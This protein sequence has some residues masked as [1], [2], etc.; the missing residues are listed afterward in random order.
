M[1]QKPSL[2]LFL[3]VDWKCWTWKWRI[4]KFAGYEIAGHEIDGP[5]CR[6]WNSRTWQWRTNLQDIKWNCKTWNYRTWNCRT[7]KCR[8]RVN[9]TDQKWRHGREIA[10]EKKYSF[11]RDNITM[12]YAKFL[13][14]QQCNTLC[15]HTWLFISLKKILP[16]AMM[17]ETQRSALESSLEPMPLRP[18]PNYSSMRRFH[19]G[20]CSSRR[21]TSI[22]DIFLSE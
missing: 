7:W 21:I 20:V 15:M 3:R 16:W 17:I 13:N 19:T 14:P 1:M 8:T 4:I 2:S 22:F 5:M 11:N 10:G 6:A 12:K 18:R 9:T